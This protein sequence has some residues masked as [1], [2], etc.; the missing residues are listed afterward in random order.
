MWYSFNYGLAHYVS[1][2]TET[3]WAG[4]PYN[5]TVIVVVAGWWIWRER[6]VYQVVR[7]RS[8]QG[9]CFQA[10]TAMDEVG[11]HRPWYVDGK[12]VTNLKETG[13]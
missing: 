7:E 3:D 1:I 5:T 10:H 6:T 8:D 2:N 4:A 9:K 13:T 11:G 12:I